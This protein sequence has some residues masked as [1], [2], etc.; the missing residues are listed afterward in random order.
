MKLV[1]DFRCL[2]CLAVTDWRSVFSYKGQS[3]VTSKCG[4]AVWLP[5]H[6]QRRYQ[7]DSH[8]RG[9]TRSYVTSHGYPG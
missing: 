3:W 2:K 9:R 1:A 4:H 6:E 8:K 5:D 7:D